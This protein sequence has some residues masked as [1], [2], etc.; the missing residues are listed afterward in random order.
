ML[1]RSIASAQRGDTAEQRMK[2]AANTALALKELGADDDISEEEA[3][4]AKQMFENMKPAEEKRTQP[5]PVEK[6]LKKTGVALPPIKV[7]FTT[8]FGLYVINIGA[9]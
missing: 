9:L 2:I 4:Q 1:F 6:E 7:I 5:A 8:I 3:A